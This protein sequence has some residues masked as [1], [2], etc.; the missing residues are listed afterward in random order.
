MKNKLI[1]FKTD[2]E[3][4]AILEQKAKNRG[5]GVSSY[6][7]TLVMEDSKNESRAN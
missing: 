1:N 7:R 2:E 4:K 5:L 6:I 3:F